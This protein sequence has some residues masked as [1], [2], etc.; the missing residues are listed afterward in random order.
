MNAVV[1]VRSGKAKAR[2]GLNGSLRTLAGKSP[3]DMIPKVRR[4][5][6]VSVFSLIRFVTI[7]T[8][9]PTRN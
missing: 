2:K 5:H 6:P 1:P 7:R 9:S 8:R 3:T 4:P